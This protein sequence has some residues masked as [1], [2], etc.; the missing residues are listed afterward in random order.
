MLI[1]DFKRK[2]IFYKY[3]NGSLSTKNVKVVLNSLDSPI[4]SNRAKY[5]NKLRKFLEGIKNNKI[6]YNSLRILF[7]YEDNFKLVC[8]IYQKYI[9]S[10]L[11]LEVLNFYLKSLGNFISLIHSDEPIEQLDKTLNTVNKYLRVNIY[12]KNTLLFRI[13]DIGTKYYILLKGKAYTLVPRKFIKTMTF[14]EYRNHLN[15]LYILGEDY[16]LEKTMHSNIKSCEIAYSEIDNNDNRIL[17]KTYKDNY[18]C[19]F[20]KYYKII[21]GEILIP[22]ENF[23][24]ISSSDDE[25]KKEKKNNKNNNDKNLNTEEKEN[26]KSNTNK[27]KKYKKKKGKYYKTLKYFNDNFNFIKKEKEIN[28]IDSI[29]SQLDLIKES[30]DKEQNKSFSSESD[31]FEI[32]QKLKKNIKNRKSIMSD[33]KEN[34]IDEDAEDGKNFNIGIPKEL[35][36]K[37]RI[38]TNK[39]KYDGGEL[40]TF[41][42]RHKNNYKYYEDNEKDENEKEDKEKEEENKKQS[43]N[44]NKNNLLYYNRVLKLRRNLFLIGYENVALLS[45]GMSFGEISLLNENHKRT[46]TIFI[47]EDSHIGRLNLSEYNSTIKSVRAKMRTDSINFLLSTKLFGDVSYLYFLNKYWIYF[48]CKKKQKGDFLF[49]IGEECDSLYIIYNGEI[50]ISSYIDKDN[51]DV[52]IDSIKYNKESKIRYYINRY[53]FSNMNSS[54]SILERKQKYCLMI[55]KKGDILGLNDL[56]NFRNNKYLCEGEVIS[57][58]LLYYEINKSIIFNQIS[59]HLNSSEDVNDTLNIENIY[60]IIKTKQ[61]FMVNKLK[62]I[63]NTIEQRFR[64]FNEDK[65]NENEKIIKNKNKLNKKDENKTSI[66]TMNKKSLSLYSINERKN[67]INKTIKINHNEKQKFNLSFYKNEKTKENINNLFSNQ[68][69]INQRNISPNNKKIQNSTKIA[70][71]NTINTKNF[72]FSQTINNSP[73]IKTLIN[74]KY[75]NNNNTSKNI[76]KEKENISHS[77]LILEFNKNNQNNSLIN[78]S[79]GTNKNDENENSKRAKV[80]YNPCKPYEFPRIY[81]DN[82]NSIY[83]NWNL[84]KKNKILKFLILNENNQRYKLQ[85]YYKLKKNKLYN[86]YFFNTIKNNSFKKSKILEYDSIENYSSKDKKDYF[87]YNLINK[88]HSEEKKLKNVNEKINVLNSFSLNINSDKGI[89][90][91]INNNNTNKRNNFP[92]NITSLTNKNKQVNLN[93]DI[94]NSFNKSKKYFSIVLNNRVRMRK[95][96][97]STN[98]LPNIEKS[99]NK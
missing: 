25:E 70:S 3:G 97:I 16:L 74:L 2:N 29:Y 96:K 55:G 39:F 28:S 99:K 63:K 75:K 19:N 72:N 42:T 59:S 95:I 64:F 41:F 30:N 90:I 15:I 92:K 26:N 60:Y 89:D 20:E 45:P 84:F 11:E 54:N 44:L 78:K 98:I 24:G 83:N 14:D 66:L 82:N 71:N 47:D 87:N 85:K 61:D 65:I 21:N 76:I 91:I 7:E 53:K 10:K 58:H 56:I 23:D 77:N 49:K 68:N 18:T 88:I 69:N 35:L 48:Q 51:I 22:I 9:K 93:P 62:N 27:K 86:N 79:I 6:K 5:E 37:D 43:I 38:P 8:D 94:V 73:N 80:I 13:G 67:N 17:R 1:Q 33:L 40:P 4:S 52:L 57:E 34:V 50:K 81:D 32:K 12:E 36:T 46:S 31:N